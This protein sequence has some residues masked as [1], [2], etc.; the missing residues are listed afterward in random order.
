[1]NYIRLQ[2]KALWLKVSIWVATLSVL[3]IV[4]AFMI[5]ELYSN[6]FERMS[7]RMA[8]DSP[9]MV[10]MAGPIP[11]GEFTEAALFMV[12]TVLFLGL[13]YGLFN[14]LI[15][16]QV[17]KQEENEGL[18]ELLIASGIGRKALFVNHVMVGI[19]INIPF[20]IITILGLAL[21]DVNG[22]EFIDNVVFISAI[23]L[24]GLLFYALTMAIGAFVTTSDMTFG[25][26]LGVL[27]GMYLYRA[28][29]DVVDM[30]YS[31][32]S[33]Y[34]WLS[35]LDA[36][37]GNNIEWLIPFSILIIFFAIAYFVTLKRDVGDGI[38]HPK[39]T[40][41]SRNISS[42]PKLL[43][44]QSRML[45]IAWFVAL[46]V[47]GLSY[48]SVLED[49][50]DIMANNFIMNAA[51]QAGQ[52]DNP[53]LFFISMISIITAIISMFPGLMIMGKL[54][55]E[56]RLRLEWMIA[57]VDIKRINRTRII[58]THIIFAVVASIAAHALY[59]ISLYSMTLLVED[60][61]TEPID[62]VYALISEGSVIVLMIGLATLFYGIS[63]KM[64]KLIWP[65]IA[66]LFI[67]SYVGT[68]LQFPDWLLN[69]S[70]FH[71]LGH[72]FVDGP[73]WNVIIILYAVALILMIIGVMF[74]SRRDLQNG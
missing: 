28:I 43:F 29:T 11:P 14:I 20:F 41:K 23:T 57:G 70:P 37:G 67:I 47:T 60:F 55:K 71:H 52:I 64:F 62:Y 45:I 48:G 74:Y 25:I 66:F 31:V 46:I 53:V 7:M 51:V 35:R 50:E 73:V 40:H 49:I 39:V 36:Y 24:F 13:A 19:L 9:A 12:V 21:V 6:P 59:A 58:I 22:S 63:Y 27:I 54:L 2:I 38:I 32:I 65:I 30:S 42:Y 17:V 1:M 68:I 10:A 26:A 72:I 8:M 61:P 44:T 69:I 16:N 4:I 18:T 34:H 3:T 33:P 56:E 15:A 5:G